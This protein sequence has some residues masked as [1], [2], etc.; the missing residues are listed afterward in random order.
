MYGILS[1]FS[2]LHTPCHVSSREASLVQLNQRVRQNCPDVHI[3][4]Q[5]SHVQAVPN[6]LPAVS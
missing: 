3:Q 2:I 5:L 6:T 4:K 1:A